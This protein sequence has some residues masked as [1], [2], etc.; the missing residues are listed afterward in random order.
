M[1]S[2]ETLIEQSDFHGLSSLLC[3]QGYVAT[4]CD[5]LEGNPEL[6]DDPTALAEEVMTRML[7]ETLD[8]GELSEGDGEEYDDEHTVRLAARYTIAEQVAEKWVAGE[9]SRPC[10][11]L[12]ELALAQAMCRNLVDIYLRVGMV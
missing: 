3:S 6:K 11:K 7:V 4:E 8:F 5:V 9:F 10:A 1:L 2:R 12:G